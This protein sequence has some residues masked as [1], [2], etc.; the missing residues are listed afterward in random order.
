MRNQ[1]SFA[2]AASQADEARMDALSAIACTVD[3]QVRAGAHS[4]QMTRREAIY[5]GLRGL[6]TA[7]TA[8]GVAVSVTATK[9]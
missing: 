8:L 5:A 1:T 2:T 4:G 9:K 6:L 3:S 7:S